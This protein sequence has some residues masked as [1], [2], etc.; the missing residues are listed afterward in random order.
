M[1]YGR[2]ASPLHDLQHRQLPEARGRQQHGNRDQ[3]IMAFQSL[4]LVYA[5][6]WLRFRAYYPPISSSR[7]RVRSSSAR[8]SL[9][10]DAASSRRRSRSFCT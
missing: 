8:A 9:A 6:Q 3:N 10:S 5:V 1:M 4:K 2:T 7:V